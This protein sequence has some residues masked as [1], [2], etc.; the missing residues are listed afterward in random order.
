MENN[1]LTKKTLFGKTL[2]ELLQ[3]VTEYSLP[4]FSARQIADWLYKKNLSSIAEM[5]NLP[6]KVRTLLAENFTVGVS[7]PL[8][9]QTSK[10]GSKK[11]LFSAIGDKY[12]EAAYIPDNK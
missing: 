5:T 8:A 3:I 11:Y 9:V 10:D 4:A 7:E 6:A 12:V 1:S 2:S